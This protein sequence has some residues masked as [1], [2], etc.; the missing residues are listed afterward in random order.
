[1]L[2]YERSGKVPMRQAEVVMTEPPLSHPVEVEVDLD[3][4]SVLSFKKVRHACPIL[5]G[6]N[7]A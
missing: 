3:A 7:A 5:E 2:E 4:G 6:A 1:M